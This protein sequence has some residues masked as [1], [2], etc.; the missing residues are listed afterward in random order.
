[1]NK[2]I[3]ALVLIP[4][5][6]F[7][8]ADAGKAEAPALPTFAQLAGRVAAFVAVAAPAEVVNPGKDAFTAAMAD[9][10]RAKSL[11]AAKAA[12]DKLALA[13]PTN[14]SIVADNAL[15]RLYRA[16]GDEKYLKLEQKLVQG[17]VA[18]FADADEPTLAANKDAIARLGG[19][20]G[21]YVQP[22]TG[23]LMAFDSVQAKWVR[24]PGWFRDGMVVFINPT[25]EIARVKMLAEKSSKT[26]TAL[27]TS[28]TWP[29]VVV[30]AY[31][32]TTFRITRA[33]E[34]VAK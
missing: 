31:G 10:V 13:V 21:V 7:A 18:R 15:V 4:F 26:D 29:E 9:F 14:G 28:A 3:T 11:G 16:T 22:D 27:G 24:R 2:L 30:P 19:K 6:A 8:K 23:L 5:V 1:M 34:I 12:A 32:R 17:A 20:V 33:G 25:R